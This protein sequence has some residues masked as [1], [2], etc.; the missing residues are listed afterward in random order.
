VTQRPD[1]SFEITTLKGFAH[2]VDVVVENLVAEE[3][4]VTEVEEVEMKEVE[5]TGGASYKLS[6]HN[7]G[8]KG[9]IARSCWAKG[10]GAHGEGD[11]D[12]DTNNGLADF[13]GVDDQALRRPPRGNAPR[14]RILPDRTNVKWCS[15]CGSWGNH[16][17]LG[18][19][20]PE[21][22]PPGDEGGVDAANVD[23]RDKGVEP[24]DG[25]PLIEED[26]S[27]VFACL[28]RAVLI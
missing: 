19:P 14:E 22:Q 20:A 28:C 11:G 7:C 6:C 1:Y 16:S 21:D 15:K 2:L 17:R 12:V 27:G 9:N 25:G 23:M 8:K 18:H 5:E 10:G 26:K 24:D 4:E 13:P 3:V